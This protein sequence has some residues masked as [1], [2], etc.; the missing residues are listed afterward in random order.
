VYNSTKGERERISR[1]LRMHA[2]HREE[3]EWIGA[4]DICAVIGLKKTFTGDTLCDPDHPILLEP[5][6]F[7][8]PVIS[9]AVEPK[10]RAD[11]DKLAIALQR[12]GGG[13][14]DFPGAY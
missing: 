7:P 9:V 6:Q 8:E 12:L 14:S 10:T 13:G 2:N 1:L 4:G 11:Q 5:I 3:V